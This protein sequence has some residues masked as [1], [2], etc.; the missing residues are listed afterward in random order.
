[1]PLGSIPSTTHTQGQGLK[2]HFFKEIV[3]MASRHMNRYS[4]SLTI[5]EM[6]MK[7]TVRYYGT[8]AGVV[9]TKRLTTLNVGKYVGQLKLLHISAKCDKW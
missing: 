6:Q 7:T 8:P 2:R 3:K 9:K 5:M 1:M 4:P